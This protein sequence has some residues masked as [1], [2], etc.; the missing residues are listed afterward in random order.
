MGLLKF[1]WLLVLVSCLPTPSF[2]T[3][4]TNEFIALGQ[5]ISNQYGN[6]HWP[7]LS[8]TAFPVLLLD[9]TGAQFFCPLQ[10]PKGFA[11]APMD[12]ATQC[13][14]YT[15]TKPGFSLQMKAT[16]PFAGSGPV[17]V[18]GAPEFTDSN[19]AAWIAT[20]L[21][22]HFHQYQMGRAGYYQTLNALDL[23]GDD[24]TGMWA[25]QF[26]FAYQDEAV[27]AAL[28]ELSAQL[29]EI[30][31]TTNPKTAKQKALQY[32]RK[33]AG[34]LQVLSEPDRRYFEFQL[35][36]EGVARYTELVM[37]EHAASGSFTASRAHDFA[38]L[39]SNLRNRIV[40]TLKAGDLAKHQRVYFYSFGAGEALVL[41]K[42]NPNWRQQYFEN[43][44]SLELFFAQS[45]RLVGDTQIK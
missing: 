11:A 32:A 5:K 45:L 15:R 7:G 27:G 26:A 38:G 28:A 16:F 40:Q 35:W 19:P 33:R 30:L 17:V 20:L 14:V 18:L 9:K 25:L 21:H 10:P 41:D 37:A 24:A 29:V 43:G 31:E 34:V 23:Q 2:G 22:E 44:F 4:T 39:S 12:P 1:F 3:Q 42:I 8:Q 13:P 36:Q 6:R